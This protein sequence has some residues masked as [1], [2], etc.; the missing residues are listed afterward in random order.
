LPSFNTSR[1]GEVQYNESDIITFVRAIL[2]FEDLLRFIIVSRPESEP[3]K[4]LQSLEDP[5]IS[6][7]VVEPKLILDNYIVEL[8]Q[9]DIKQLHG[10]QQLSDYKIYVILTVPKGQPEK[11]SVNLQGPLI[12]NTKNLKAIQMVLNNPEYAIRFNLFESQSALTP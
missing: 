1:F 11:I 4:W 3:F 2:G 10:N 7:V 5:S 9:H 12:V 6:F 8:S